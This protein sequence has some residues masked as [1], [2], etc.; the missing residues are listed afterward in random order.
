MPDQQSDPTH[1]IGADPL[2]ATPGAGRGGK[3]GDPIPEQIEEAEKTKDTEHKFDDETQEE[4]GA[5]AAKS[6][7]HVSSP[8]ETSEDSREGHR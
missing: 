5:D 6:P 8:E 3:E 7:G 4:R 2:T 1:N